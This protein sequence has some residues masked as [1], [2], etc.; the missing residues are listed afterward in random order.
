M[1]TLINMAT[2]KSKEKRK[3]KPANLKLSGPRILR[4]FKPW[5]SDGMDFRHVLFVRR[6]SRITRS[7][8]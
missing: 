4:L 8:I 3:M 1:G 7:Q 2:K 5:I 6:N